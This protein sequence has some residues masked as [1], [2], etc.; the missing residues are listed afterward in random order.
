MLYWQT[1][2]SEQTVSF[3]ITIPD[4]FSDDDIEA[5]RLALAKLPDLT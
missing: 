2:Q 5:A 1:A 3:V 4:L